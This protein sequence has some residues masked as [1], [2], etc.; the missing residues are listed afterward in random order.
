METDDKKQ[1]AQAKEKA[2]TRSHTTPSRKWCIAQRGK[3]GVI[4]VCAYN[5][6][7]KKKEEKKV[8]EK[9]K[10]STG[11]LTDSIVMTE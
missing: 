10:S 1:D 6:K 2:N 4:Y 3:N 8:A 7:K 5:E 11:W 9:E